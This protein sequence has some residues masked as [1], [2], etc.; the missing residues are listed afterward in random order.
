MESVKIICHNCNTISIGIGNCD[1]CNHDLNQLKVLYITALSGYNR[2]IK[3][4]EQKNIIKAWGIIKE[5]LNICPFLVDLLQLGYLLALEKGNYEYVYKILNQLKPV[6]ADDEYQI[7]LSRLQDHIKTYNRIVNND[8]KFD[9]QNDQNYSLYHLTVL[10][11]ISGT[12]VKNI[13]LEQIQ[14]ID[15][16]FSSSLGLIIKPQKNKLK[17]ILLGILTIFS[18]CIFIFYWN[19]TILIELNKELS[20]KIN[21]SKIEIDEQKRINTSFYKLIQ[22]ID[23]KNDVETIEIIKMNE[24]SKIFDGDKSFILNDLCKRLYDEKK[25]ELLLEVPYNYYRKPDAFYYVYLQNKNLSNRY[26]K[27]EEFIKLFKNNNNYIAPLLEEI[28][29]YYGSISNDQKAYKYA[30][31]LENHVTDYPDNNIY[32]NS[33]VQNI[34]EKGE[35]NATIR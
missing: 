4:I 29:K 30:I 31:L 24:N 15:P 10:Y 22:S 20:N 25:Y 33:Y 16:I 23:N 28:V 35:N 26:Q 27:I 2:S 12:A 18:L 17:I 5:Q 11:T 14:Q 6:I 13:I 32:L 3:L 8:L 19:N 21:N 34:L 7:K 1:N 9:E